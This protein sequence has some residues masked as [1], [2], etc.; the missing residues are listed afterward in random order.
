MA[1]QS[2]S[3]SFVKWVCS[4]VQEGSDLDLIDNVEMLHVREP[5]ANSLWD[6]EDEDIRMSDSTGVSASLDGEIFSRG[7]KCQESNIGDSDNTRDG[8]KIVGGAIGS[9]SR[10]IGLPPKVYA[11]VS[12]HKVTKELW[13]IIQLLMQETSLMKQERECKLY[14]EFHKFG[15]KKGESL[16]ESYLRFSLLLNDMNIY[17]MKMEQFQVNIKFLNTLPP[18]WSKFVIDVKLVRDLHT[19]NVDQLHAYLGQY[20]FYANESSTPLSITCLPNDFQ[21][22]V[23]HNV[24]NSS[25][26][27]PQV[28]YAPLVNQQSDISQP[29][30]GLIVLVFPKGDD[31]I[32]AINHMMAFLTAVVTT[33]TYTSGT[34]GNN[35]GKQRTVVCYNCKGERHIQILHKEELAFLADL[36]IAEAQTT[37]NVITYN[38]AYQADDLDAYD[39]DCD[40]I[41]SAKIALVANLS[42]YGSDDL[43]EVHNQDNVTPNVI[44]QDVQAMPLFEQLNIVNQSETKITSDS[45]I[46][47]YSQYL[48][49]S[50]HVAVQNLNIPAQQDELILSVIAQLKTQV[51]N[52]TN[53]I[54]DN[55]NV[56]ETLTAELERYKDQVRILKEG[57]NVDKVSDRALSVEID[58]L[59]QSLS[60]HLKEM[61]SL[62]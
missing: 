48:S 26:S 23:H 13:E 34:S 3:L 57:N 61:E 55:K 58:N 37:Q 17:N 9:C 32:D 62:I 10:G 8:G 11:L 1:M 36:G 24:Y 22:L 29:D 20:E 27:I 52:C 16:R 50:Q 43:A 42:H 54:L 12:N 21:S 30:S 19:T 38:A 18:E 4:V 25:S 45:N 51:V 28:E 35:S 53:I 31:L 7:K 41:Y 40:E 6:N 60:E 47:P 33:R 44:N 49:E 56:N 59:K 14:D 39:S 5:I 15:Y 2:Y 46:I